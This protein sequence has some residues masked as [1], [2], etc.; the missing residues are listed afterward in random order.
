[1]IDADTAPKTQTQDPQ[2]NESPL[3]FIDD[4]DHEY[5]VPQIEEFLSMVFHGGVEEGSHRLTYSASSNRPRMPKAVKGL[6]RVLEGSKARSLY[7]N[8]CSCVPD[9]EG[10]LRHRKELFNAMH[11]LVLD[12][13]GTKVPVESI[14]ENMPP[15]YIIE[16]SKGNFQYGYVLEEPIRDVGHAT[17]LVQLAS[18]KGL[19]DKGGVMATK[20]VR[21]PDG[22]NGKSEKGKQ[23]YPVTL[24]HMDGPL[25]P[26]EVLVK[27]LNVTIDETLV[28]WPIILDGLV[29]LLKKHK[30][31]HRPLQPSAMSGDGVIDPVLEWLYINEIIV[32]DSGG[33]WVEVICP[34]NHNHSDGS[35]V[36]GYSPVGRGS[37]PHKRAFHCFHEHCRDHKTKDFAAYLMAEGDFTFVPVVDTS[38][39]LLNNFALDTPANKVWRINRG[40]PLLYEMAGFVSM[41]KNMPQS[42]GFKF[43]KGGTVVGA[44]VAPNVVWDYSPF[45]IKVNGARSEPAGE[46]VLK[47][48]YEDNWVNMFSGV[49]F[50]DGDYDQSHVTKFTDYVR[51]LLPIEK[52]YEYFLDWI[53]A[54]IQNPRFRG[55]GLI[56]CTPAYGVGRS[57]LAKMLSSLVGDHNA[58]TIPFDTLID[59]SSYNSWEDKLLVIVS[60]AQETAGNDVGR[61]PYKAYEALKQRVDTTAATARINPK[62]GRQYDATLCSSYLILT[63]HPDAVAVPATDRRLTIME[64]PLKAESAEFFILLNHWLDGGDWAKHVFRWLRKREIDLT[65]LMLPL[66]TTGKQA[67]V[68]G[69]ETNPARCAAALVDYLIDNELSFIAQDIAKEVLQKAIYAIN[70]TREYNDK[71]LSR[72][73]S[74]ELIQFKHFKVKINKKTHRIRVALRAVQQGMVNDYV[75]GA[76]YLKGPELPD[77]L[78]TQAIHEISALNVSEIVAYIVDKVV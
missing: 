19:T 40:E 10:V 2:S 25:Y 39:D 30:T 58:A 35:F 20:I 68:D 73:L 67:M 72:C 34:W 17:A 31:A 26:V 15:T 4:V 44:Y 33:E 11:V 43:G 75:N 5:N 64:N 48:K 42:Y 14:P 23:Y 46:V 52:E 21:L 61:G 53:S 1:M 45:K 22:V 12:D 37:E 62:Y 63:N 56:M 51:Y 70:D 59:A 41:C 16:S 55:T 29:P 60:E 18:I 27:H 50:G 8:T 47:D 76:P 71:Y 69:T 28:T 49:D 66:D 32:S 24:G 9:V 36:A 77:G 54:K 65:P 74:A 3:H 13:V 78:K 6:K 38:F 7:F 57:T